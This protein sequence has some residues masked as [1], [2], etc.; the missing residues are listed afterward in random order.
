MSTTV[1]AARRRLWAAPAIAVVAVSAFAQQ[2]IQQSG[3]LFDANPQVGSGG[4]NYDRPLSPLLSGNALSTGNVGR[5][6]SLRIDSPIGSP[7]TFQGPLGSA[8]LSSFRRDAVSVADAGSPFGGL[9]A[10]I[11]YDPARTVFTPGYYGAT[12][13]P[14]PGLQ[15]EDLGARRVPTGRQ[16]LPDRYPALPQAR[17]IPGADRAGPLDLRIGAD[18]PAAVDPLTQQILGITPNRR[19][20]LNSSIFGNY[21]PPSPVSTLP[22]P[23]PF[24]PFDQMNRSPLGAADRSGGTTPADRL[25]EQSDAARLAYRPGDPRPEPLGTPLD[26]IIRGADAGT[27]LDPTLRPEALADRTAALGRLPGVAPEAQ[28]LASELGRPG[29]QTQTL[30]PG[31]PVGR[32]IMSPLGMPVLPGMDIFTDMQLAQSLSNDPSAAW[33]A[34]MKSVIQN[35]PSLAMQMNDLMQMSA[36]QFSESIVGTPIQ[37]FVGRGDSALNETLLAAETMLHSG[38]Y[39]DA[40]QQYDRA[41]LMDP[42][43]PL[44]LLGKGNAALAAG[45]YMAAAHSIVLGMQRY[46]EIMHFDVRLESFMG[47]EAIDIRRADLLKQLE[48]REDPQV[49]FLLGYLEY[50]SGRKESGMQ[51]LKKAATEAAPGSFIQQ[52]PALLSGDRELPPP[53][54]PL[55]SMLSLPGTEAPAQTHP[56]F[57]NDSTRRSNPPATG[58]GERKEP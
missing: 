6:L 51:H 37:T 29:G 50:Y 26:L 36:E 35:N 17:P 23:Q 57:Q 30:M 48:Q 28:R 22:E 3:R 31:A 33:F 40:V 54:L 55:S 16:Y 49:R 38:Q 47:G 10:R 8:A 9:S 39:F 27:I 34:E 18:S 19:A 42:L 14:V 41:R 53:K 7:Y 24:S 13:A 1:P 32:P 52:F 2:Q 21:T 25:R 11:Y 20:E 15:M 5:G 12:N 4:L 58:G 46:P 56:L 44:P 45:D 43:N